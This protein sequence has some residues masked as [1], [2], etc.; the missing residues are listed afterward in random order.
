[1]AY[2]TKN[3]YECKR[4]WA[5]KRMAE[6]AEVET[7]TTEQHGVLEW[8]CTVRH[9]VHCNQGDFFNDEAP[10]NS[11][12]WNYID[13]ADGCGIIRDRLK[14]AGLPVLRWSFSVDDYM[15]DGICYELGYTEEEREEEREKCFEMAE[16]FNSDIENYLTQIDKKH[17]TSYCPSGATRV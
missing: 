3:A 12:Y 2:L 9:N 10:N 14:A 1:M 15:T 17:G 13:S 16:K 8:L 11:E 4:E 6:N 5:A 7:L